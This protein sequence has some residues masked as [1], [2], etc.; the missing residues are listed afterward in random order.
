MSKK[1]TLVF[2]GLFSFI[3]C[4]HFDG[5]SAYLFTEFPLL[6]FFPDPFD[7]HIVVLRTVGKYAA[8]A[9]LDNPAPDIQEFW[10][11]GTFFPQVKRTVAEQAVKILQSP[12][13]G[14]ILT[15]CI[16]EKAAG[17]LHLILLLIP[18][19]SDREQAFFPRLTGNRIIHSAQIV[20]A[21]FLCF[22]GSRCRII[23]NRIS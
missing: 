9:V 19:T 22:L 20:K 8:A 21:G 4:F 18:R 3:F 2:M 17:I 16:R 23:D 5:F 15:G 13:A 7:N 10:R 11:A 12:V 1:R 14:I 6:V